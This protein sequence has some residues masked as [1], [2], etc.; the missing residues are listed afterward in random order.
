MSVYSTF[1][2]CIRVS[3]ALCPCQHLVLQ[4]LILAIGIFI[5]KFEPLAIASDFISKY[6]W[7]LNNSGTGTLTFHVVENRSIILHLALCV[8]GPHP[9]IQ[10][11]SDCVVPSHIFIGKNPYVNGSVHFKPVSFKGHLFYTGPLMSN[12]WVLTMISSTL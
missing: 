3:G 6:S 2:Q 12:R 11:T 5:P 10:P 4:P 8:W 9:L 1:Q 7:S